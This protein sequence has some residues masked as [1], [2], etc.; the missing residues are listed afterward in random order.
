MRN[1]WLALATKSARI[2]SM[3]RVWLRSRKVSTDVG[4]MS[5]FASGATF[6]SN[7]R[8]TGTR[9]SHVTRSAAVSGADAPKGIEHIGGAQAAGQEIAR[10]Q[11][12]KQLVRRIVE[13]QHT[14]IGRDDEDGFRQ[15]LDEAADK[16]ECVEIVFLIHRA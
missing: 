6:T 13:Q 1:S 2:L 10:T 8:S 3:R 14:V 12:R 11:C 16:F 15:S 4:L 5:G 7:T 9:S